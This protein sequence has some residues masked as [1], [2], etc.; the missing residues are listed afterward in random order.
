[1]ESLRS[2]GT[3]RRDLVICC[4]AVVCLFF[5]ASHYDFF[6]H[7]AEWS[8]AHED[9][10]LDEVFMALVLGSVGFAWFAYRRW[11]ETRELLSLRLEINRQLN[12]EI[13]A[14]ELAQRTLKESDER[15]RQ[16]T[17]M[18]RLGYYIWDAVEDRCIYCSDENARMHGLTADQYMDKASGLDG[19]FTLT[20]PE[21]RAA[22]KAGME[23]LRRGEIFEMEYRTISP[24]GDIR[25]LREIAHPVF[26]DDGKVIREIG[27]C[28]DISE[29]KHAETLLAR[30]LDITPSLFALFDADDRLVICNQRYRDLNETEG[31]RI[32]PGMHFET[33]LRT[34]IN[35]EGIDGSAAEKSAWIAQ[36]LDR[37]NNPADHMEYR[38][39]DGDW[40]ELSD[41]ILEDGSVFTVSSVTTER[42]RVEEELRQAQKMEAVGQLTGGVAHDFNNLLGVIVGNT[43]L[44]E[45]EV[46]TENSSVQAIYRSS[47][48]GA[49]L[50]Q[51]LLAFSRRQPLRPATIDLA[52][53]VGHL[54]QILGRTLGAAIEINVNVAASI[55]PVE[56]DPGQLENALLNL[57]INARDAMPDGGTLEFTAENFSVSQNLGIETNP[58]NQGDYVSL[59]VRDTGTGIPADIIENVIEPF[60]TTKDVG[61]GSGL[62]LSMVYGF[63]KQSN[64]D[65][66]IESEP[67]QGTVVTLFLPRAMT[68]Q[69]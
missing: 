43:E 14:R 23:A 39:S 37:R 48:R 27:V 32:V 3:A 26:D 1:M 40:L 63:A 22:V 56:A 42:K 61:E 64:G 53:L 2:V 66:R 10:E 36:R 46:G 45:D 15:L 12:D 54:H 13:V 68:A 67:G 44:L 69:D 24:N 29:M 55:W 34:L 57:A 18:A 60:F 49:E 58:L 33:I 8:E 28:L 5:V 47:Q 4:I 51:R 52:E 62:G 6:E 41:H 9:W 16:A 11:H 25:F 31:F 20:H 35:K 59:Q 17:Q 50:T 65:L 19:E 21:D 30:A 38:R 7:W